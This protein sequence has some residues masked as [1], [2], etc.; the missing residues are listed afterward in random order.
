MNIYYKNRKVLLFLLPCLLLYTFVVVLPLVQSLIY[1]FYSWKGFG[2][3]K[4]V[5]LKNYIDLFTDDH[6]M[7]IAVR[8][9]FLF[10][11]I[12]LL[13]MLPLS[14]MLAYVLSE[15]V[16]FGKWFSILFYLPGVVSTV[17][18]SLMWCAILNADIG[19]LNAL[20]RAVGLDS[21]AKVWL[22]DPKIT[23]F[24]I[25]FVN[26]WQ[27]S[28]YHMLI[29]YTSLQ[30]IPLEIYESA[31]LDGATDWKRLC[32]VT[33]P[34]MAS[35]IKMNAMLIIIGSF[36]CFDIVYTMTSGGPADS[37]QM[38]G[39][40]MYHSTFRRFSFGSGSAISMIIFLLCVLFT[41]LLQKVKFGKDDI[42]Y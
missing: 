30:V 28:G 33:I 16:R 34:L 7:Q 27:W 1:S 40:Y 5:G 20:L 14:F 19:P 17:I 35:S 11:G 21:L 4:P 2:E 37:T 38:L 3:M 13:V 36:K 39:T 15:G 29:F 26:L 12:S 42:Q 22:G 6:I 10:A 25:I 41:V 31:A 32:H 24:V 18:V 9:T 8:N 23:I